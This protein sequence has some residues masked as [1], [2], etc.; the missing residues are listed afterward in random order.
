MGKHRGL[1]LDVNLDRYNQRYVLC[2]QQLSIG[3]S[4]VNVHCI[5]A[6]KGQFYGESTGNASKGTRRT[7]GGCYAPASALVL[8]GV[9]AHPVGP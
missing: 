7:H 5:A 2:Y 8:S 9:P 3:K 4:M 6:A 1:R